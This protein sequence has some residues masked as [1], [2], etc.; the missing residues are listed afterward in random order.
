MEDKGKTFGIDGFKRIVSLGNNINM[1][2]IH[3]PERLS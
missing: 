3:G 2:A 1:F